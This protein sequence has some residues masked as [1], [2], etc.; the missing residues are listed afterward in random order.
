MSFRQWYEQR[1]DVIQMRTVS[2]DGKNG[3][4][5]NFLV[6]VGMSISLLECRNLRT[7]EW[8]FIICDSGEFYKNVLINFICG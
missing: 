5:T 1:S 7:A 2:G 8:I 4:I 3:L 6:L